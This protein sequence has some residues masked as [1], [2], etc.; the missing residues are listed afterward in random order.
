MAALYYFKQKQKPSEFFR[1]IFNTSS[2]SQNAHA[3][4][5]KTYS[6]IYTGKINR[7][8]IDD[9]QD[10]SLSNS[11]ETVGPTNNN[12]EVE[13]SSGIKMTENIL[14]HSYRSEK[15]VPTNDLSLSTKNLTSSSK[16][17]S[18]DVAY[19]FAQNVADS[20]KPSKMTENIL[21]DSYQAGVSENK[22]ENCYEVVGNNVGD[23][24][25]LQVSSEYEK[26]DSPMGSKSDLHA[27]HDLAESA[28]TSVTSGSAKTLR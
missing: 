13:T 7:A 1:D 8:L 16:A 3:A 15:D 12:K 4:D 24:I 2:K 27:P 18:T 10:V 9:H 21:Y 11:Y 25:V 14:Y 28:S 5:T 20:S 6:K 23:P 17:A 22:N 26:N 19:D